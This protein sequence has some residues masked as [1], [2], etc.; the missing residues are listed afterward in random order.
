MPKAQKH[1]AWA[2]CIAFVVILQSWHSLTS[3]SNTPEV[4]SEVFIK[5]WPTCSNNKDAPFQF[6]AS[7]PLHFARRP[8]PALSKIPSILHVV[9]GLEE[10]SHF[11]LIQYL[12]LASALNVLAPERLIM[13]HR[14]PPSGMYWDLLEHHVEMR[15]A[16]D[17]TSIFNKTVR[18][19]AHKADV[20]RLEALIEHGGIYLDLDVV[21]LRPFSALLMYD[22]V[23]GQEGEEGGF[24]LC[25]AVILA[26]KHSIFLRRWYDSYRTFNDSIWNYHSV[27]LPHALSRAHS[28]EIHVAGHTT[29]FW[30]LWDQP[31]LE[32]IFAK[33]DYDYSNNL[34]VHTWNS[35]ARGQRAGM[36]NVIA[37][38]SQTW[39]LECRS[40]L[41]SM[42]RIYMP[43][44]LVSVIIICDTTR[45]IRGALES[46]VRQP[47]PSWEIIVVDDGKCGQD[48][49]RMT[50]EMPSVAQLQNSVTII[51][52]T[53]HGPREGDLR[54]AALMQARGLWAL[55]LSPNAVVPV[56]LLS[57]AE[58]LMTRDPRLMLIAANA[59]FD[60]V[61]FCATLSDTSTSVFLFRKSLWEQFRSHKSDDGNVSCNLA[62]IA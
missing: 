26:N 37:E 34:A 23:M 12:S 16:R 40:T 24:G 60:S 1:V 36:S 35:A 62:T 55:V 15:Q 51:Q 14:K 20:I 28:S 11:G 22:F 58:R 44:P 9:F 5:P 49:R 47:W 42:L 48:A 6:N 18:H 54:N 41:L 29:F 27:Q 30:P 33:H 46:L 17:V 25:N 2:T 39:L 13:H 32:E 7:L 52:R 50:S 19:Y 43:I 21:V 59:D 10:S 61:T 45:P 57:D 31:G 4:N 38:M 3:Y 8:H 56:N 53:N